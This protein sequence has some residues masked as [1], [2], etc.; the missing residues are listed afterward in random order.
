MKQLIIVFSLIVIA[1]SVE[2]V[3]AQR[4]IAGFPAGTVID[5]SYPFD[6]TT[7]YWPTAEAFHLEKDFEG[8][9][10]KDFIIQL[11]QYSAAEHGGN[12][13]MLRST[14]RRAENP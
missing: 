8:T 2:F 10:E 7:V 3:E 4:R 5:L 11:T 6:S 14:S 13:S 12:T 9:T 1:G